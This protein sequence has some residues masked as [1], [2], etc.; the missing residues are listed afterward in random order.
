MA[1][2]TAIKYGV[3]SDAESRGQPMSQYDPGLERVAAALEGR[4]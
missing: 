4:G 1:A 2:T 3:G